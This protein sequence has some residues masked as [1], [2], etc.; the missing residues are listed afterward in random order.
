MWPLYM[1]LLPSEPP[2][3]RFDFSLHRLIFPL[4]LFYF[5]FLAAGPPLAFLGVFSCHVSILDKDPRLTQ[6]M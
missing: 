3:W 6:N 4:T 2:G 1:D 5:L